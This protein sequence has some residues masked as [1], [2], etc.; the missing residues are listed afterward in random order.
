MDL[1]GLLERESIPPATA[2][3]RREGGSRRRSAE[4]SQKKENPRS[5]AGFL[6]SGRLDLNQRPPTPHLQGWELTHFEIYSEIEELRVLI[7]ERK[8]RHAL[9]SRRA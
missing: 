8:E 9:T 1:C 2:F 6:E 5:P 7:A 4:G 3:I